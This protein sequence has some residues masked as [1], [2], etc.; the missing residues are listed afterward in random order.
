MANEYLKR[1]PTSTGNRNVFTWSGWV[2]RNKINQDYYLFSSGDDANN[3]FYVSIRRDANNNNLTVLFRDGDTSSHTLVFNN[4][5]FR[6]P[7]SWMHFVVSV[8]TTIVDSKS[9]RCK[10]YI[11]G[12]R[13]TGWTTDQLANITQNGLTSTNALELH[14][15]GDYSVSSSPGDFQIFDYF[16]VDGQA[17]TPDV[18]GFYKDGDGYMSSGTSNATDFRP[19]QWMPHSPTKIKKDINRRGGFGVNGFYLPMNDSSN[20]GAD[21]HC[22]PNSIIKLKGEDL[23]Q[24]RNGAPTTSDAFVS[25][26]RQETGTLGFDGCIKVDSYGGLVVSDHSDLDLGTGDYTIEGFYYIDDSNVSSGYHALFDFRGT[27]GANG[28]YPAMFRH[29]NGHIYFYLDSVVRIDNVGFPTNKWTH[30]A[31]SRSSG[32]TR[33]FV[34]GVEGGSFSDTISYLC[35]ELKIGHSATQSNPMRGFISNFRVVKGTALY[36]S[37]F[38]KPTQPLE[39]I[40]NTIVLMAQSETSSTAGVAPA[41]IAT[42]TYNSNSVVFATRNELTGSIVL[43]V[44]G[45]STTTDVNQVVNGNFDNGTTSWTAAT[46]ATL[47]N[48]DGTLRITVTQT[49]GAEQT[50]SGLTVGERYTLSYRLRTD[51]TNFANFRITNNS[52]Q[53]YIGNQSNTDWVKINHSFTANNSLVT[54]YPYKATGG[55]AEFDNFVVKQE[56]APRDYSADIRGS[57]SNKTVQASLGSGGVGYDIP[58]YYGS[59]INANDNN[60]GYAFSGADSAFVCPGDFTVEFWFDP[61]VATQPRGNPR[62]L[63]QTNNSGGKWDIYIDSNTSTNRIYTMG[64]TV[65]L[66]GGNGSSY[67]NFVPGQWN[68]FCLERSGSAM[69]TYMNGVAVYTQTYTNTIGT[70]DFLYLGSY[71]DQSAAPGYGIT[72]KI[73]D[74][75]FYKGVAKYK[76]GFDV[77]KPYTPVG[78]EAFRTTADT[79]KN[80]FCTWNPISPG[81]SE[82]AVFSN[83]NL[84]ISDPT[85]GTSQGTGTIGPSSGK[86]YYEAR[87]ES[88]TGASH[89]IG[90]RAAEWNSANGQN[91]LNYRSNGSVYNYSSA[92]TSQA[93]YTDGDIIGIAF[94]PTNGRL[95]FSKNG[96]WTDGD[97]STGS[98]QNVNYT[99]SATTAF[100]AFDNVSGTQTW[101]TNFG[102]NPSFSGT[103]TA[104]TNADDSGKGLFKYAPPSGFL[105][106][107]EDNLPT[108]AI[109][110]PGDYMRTVLYEGDGNYGRSITGVGFQ[111]DFVWT[112]ERSSTSGHFLL[113]SVRGVTNYLSS[114]STAAEGSSTNTIISFDSSGYSIGASGAFNE[115]NQT[116]VAWCWKAGGAAVSN[117]DGSITSVVSVNQTAG[118][119]IVSYTGTGANATV[120]HGLG[121]APK[122]MIFKGRF[123]SNWTVYHNSLPAPTTSILILNSTGAAV[124]SLPSYWNS[125]APTSTVFSLSTDA[126]VNSTNAAGM[127]AYCW[128]EIEGFSKF[129]SYVGNGS[130]DGPFV[131]CGFKP[132][133]VMIKWADGSAGWVI[134]DSSRTSTNPST[135]ALVPNSN[136]VELDASTLSVDFLSNG[137][138]IRNTNGSYNN[139]ST[140]IFAAFA[141]SPFQTA[142]AK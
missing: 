111:P 140:Y 74:F 114:H 142:N 15:I 41:T 14:T 116:Y 31:L 10:V 33:L 125:T 22:A 18:F 129:G 61:V 38:T 89:M 42:Y 27:S 130:A 138:K 53:T 64:G 7:G 81:F 120:G 106:L 51:G 65:A 58:S 83:G 36:T 92:A 62:I 12:K 59:A 100:F 119:S 126:N 21:F 60:C 54:L 101:D 84:T 56:D 71:G 17:L 2:K 44:S 55:W 6:D 91:S 137:F 25:E 139:A 76:G 82:N 28:T 75:R 32:T 46:G 19:G 47:T 8:N 70:T 67:G 72:G 49:A 133:W 124:T 107:C 90:I 4:N 9:D 94:D 108:P 123:A 63:G 141:E 40:N 122:M 43:A 110:D 11:N 57:G 134:Q 99:P 132:A 16:L 26:L 79:C 115:S 20:P 66:T 97:P 105:A 128:A 39:N 86:W 103:T 35:R 13:L 78:I 121:V 95:W 5:S 118:F 37:N 112:K 88:V 127:I 102:Q 52:V 85:S 1:T 23:P 45:A 117:T 104:G 93:T 136:G 77:P 87:A 3:I 50:L 48:P 135:K 131:Y 96:V 73:Q 98:G 69:T 29:P 113:D 109:A 68:H 34:D 24:P 80:N 30:V